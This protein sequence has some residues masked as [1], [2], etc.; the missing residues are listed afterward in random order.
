MT[1][2]VKARRPAK[3]PDG[4]SSAPHAPAPHDTAP[5]AAAPAWAQASVA[6]PFALGVPVQRKPVIGRADDAYEREAD[7]VADRVAARNVVSAPLPISRVSAAALAPPV[8]PKSIGD[9]TEHDDPPQPNAGG[10]GIIQRTPTVVQR[11]EDEKPDEAS[12]AVQTKP[13]AS[14]VAQRAEDD[15]RSDADSGAVQTKPESAAVVQRAEDDEK[16]E[17]SAAVQTKPAAAASVQRAEDDAKPDEDTG[18]VQTKAAASTVVQREE[19]DDE[20]PDKDSGA[21]KQGAVAGGSPAMRSAA[22]TAISTRGPGSPLPAATRATLESGIG[23]DL[24]D[25]RVHTGPRAEDATSKLRARAFTHGRD[26]WLG[27]GE[28]PRDTKLMAHELTHVVQQRGVVPRAPIDPATDE[29]EARRRRQQERVEPESGSRRADDAKNTAGSETP[30]AKD[31]ERD[32]QAGAG[33]PPRPHPSAPR[34]RPRPAAPPPTM[35]FPAVAPMSPAEPTPKQPTGAPQPAGAPQPTA[36]AAAAAGARVPFALSGVRVQAPAA[37]AGKPAVPGAPG[38]TAE[39]SPAPGAPATAT[40]AV[41]ATTATVADGAAGSGATTAPADAGTAASPGDATAKSKEKGEKK[42]ATPGDPAE[43]AADVKGKPTGAPGAPA[44]AAGAEGAAA[45]GGAA[46]MPGLAAEMAGA[47]GGTMAG[48]MTGGGAGPATETGG[49]ETPDTGGGGEIPAQD[50]ASAAGETAAK[51][52]AAQPDGDRE[53]EAAAEAEGEQPG[54]GGETVAEPSLGSA[55]A[56]AGGGDGGGGVAEA[57]DESASESEEATSEADA[58]VPAPA[59][60]AAGASPAAAEAASGGGAGAGAGAAEA[61]S[62]GMETVDAGAEPSPADN[63]T[64]ELSPAERDAGL[65]SIGEG[66]GEYAGGGGGGG[67]AIPDPP[68]P[69]APAIPANDPEAAIAAVSSLPPNRLK[70]AL[71]QVSSAA[72]SDVGQQRQELSSMPPQVQRPSGSPQT[73]DAV[74]SADVPTA[75]ETGKKVE[76]APEGAAVATPQPAPLPAPPPAPI[77]AVA[78]PEEPAD[79]VAGINRLPTSDPGLHADAGPAPTVQL[80]GNADPARV[81]AQK[82]EIEA[83]VAREEAQGRADMAQPLGEDDI[84]PVVPDETLKATIPAGGGAAGA[85]GGPGGGAA[86]AG[87]AGGGGDDAASIIAQEQKGDEIRAAAGQARGDM[88]ARRQEHATTDAQERASTDQEIA[89]LETEN[90]GEQNAERQAARAEAGTSRQEWST[91][92]K[93]LADGAR[94]K[95]EAETASGE[96]EVETE[97]THADTEARGHIRT[98]NDDATRARTDAEAEAARK[99]AEAKQQADSGGVLSWIK[100]KAKAFF[101]RIK[102]GIKAAFDKARALVRAAIEKAKQLAVAVIEKARQAIVSVIRRVGDALIAIGDKVLADFPA[103]RDRFREGIKKRVAGAEAAVNRFAERLK[104]DVVAALDALGAALDKALGLLEAGLLAAVDV[105]DKAVSAALDA[106][107]AVVDALGTFAVLIKDVAAGPGRWISNLGAA[108]VDGIKNHLWA[109]FK[110]QVKEWFNAKLESV[111]G[112]GTAIWDVLTK[113]GISIAQVGTMAFEALKAAIPT[114]LVQLLV[115]KLVAMIVPA[116]G[117]VMAIIEGLQAAWGAVQRILAAIGAFVAFLK[118]VRGGGAGPQFATALAAAAI[119]VIEFVAQWLLRRLMKP[120]KAVGGKI[121]AIAQRIMARIKKALKKVA[122]KLKKVGKK[123]LKKVK[124]AGKWV[125]KKLGIKGKKKQKTAADRRKE[126]QDRLDRAVRELTPRIR[127]ATGGGGIRKVLLWARLQGWRMQYRLSSLSVQGN[128][129][130]ARVNPQADVGHIIE[131]HREELIDYIRGLARRLMESAR[132]RAEAEQIHQSSTQ[133]Q[134]PRAISV[135]QTPSNVPPPKP[136]RS[137]PQHEV[138]PHHGFPGIAGAVA[139]QQVTPPY[140]ASALLRFRGAATA[141]V[142]RVGAWGRTVA[143][144]IV[145]SVK[146]GRLIR[147]EGKYTQHAERFAG[148]GPQGGTA[149]A[150]L[151]W[152]RSRRNALPPGVDVDDVAALST[153]LLAQERLRNP[154]AIVTGIMTLDLVEKHGWEKALTAF[155]PMAPQ[156]DAQR[157]SAALTHVLAA[158][159]DPSLVVTP[160]HLADAE[161]QMTRE[162][163][164]IKVWVKTMDLTFSDPSNERKVILELKKAIRKRIMKAFRRAR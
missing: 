63:M 64:A 41:G 162:I 4:A 54:P 156:G 146:G 24:R 55:E 66:G 3:K 157:Q 97:R 85:G 155:N 21:A 69:A 70:S 147:G 143:N 71:G 39:T 90:A 45:A 32:E 128:R 81:R 127:A 113:G 148:M 9:R 12:G 114:A 27:R 57:A 94:T 73:K 33:Q 30:A 53:A 154:A 76:K 149:S 1:E 103:L 59:P 18:A 35:R 38:T 91:Q 100:S 95:A 117:A 60:V 22:A 133:V 61:V 29:E 31:E 89:R 7:A 84:Y 37:S 145:Q 58:E 152:I 51:M 93:A 88:A 50:E 111:L 44:G 67:S 78:T 99:R 92:Q 2:T 86:G 47:G 102:A 140:V 25:V 28:S 49:A 119:A 159:R 79:V 158:R 129:I 135:G 20:T 26:I 122:A 108:V 23:M 136:P 13:A 15:E 6:A 96:T 134:T 137:I 132:A 107:Q 77:Q 17:D 141:L 131:L 11:A 120:A 56:A 109:A 34:A 74:G 151:A 142:G 5:D 153:I 121:K 46:A 126:K 14:A 36:P 75:G 68:E 163:E 72:K 104:K 139:R 42:D 112:L 48:A 124:K 106:A 116:A 144:M 87:A 138:E 130:V 82:A 10:P 43:A 98:G 105:V 83:G 118:A 8:Q 65:A 160:E 101:D 40:T 150:V 52:D 123:I 164:L 125:K 16:P 115:E 161:A 19:D 110:A 62:P 80:A